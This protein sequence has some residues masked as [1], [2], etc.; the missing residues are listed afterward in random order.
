MSNVIGLKTEDSPTTGRRGVPRVALLTLALGV[1]TVVATYLWVEPRWQERALQAASIETLRAKAAVMPENARVQYYLGKRLLASGD[2]SGA[3]DAL[4]RAADKSPGDFAVWKATADAAGALNGSLGAINL[5]AA[6]VKNNPDNVVARI[7]FSQAYI[8]AGAYRQA[9]SEAKNA[10]ELA[11]KSAEA[12]R[13][14]GISAVAAENA[15]DAEN[16]LR[17]AIMLAP[18]DAEN[19]SALGN[20]LALQGKWDAALSPYREAVRLRP[21][22]PLAL[23]SL[24][25]TLLSVTTS[26]ANVTEAKTLLERSA[27]LKIDL[28]VTY[29]YLGRA[30]AAEG[31]WKG[32][33]TALEHAVALDP[34]T[35]DPYFDLARVYDHFGEKDAAAAARTKH[36]SISQFVVWR[37]R[38]LL[39][40][41]R[42]GD[43]DEGKRL[44]WELARGYFAQQRFQQAVEQYRRLV[45]LYP[46]RADIQSEAA[47]AEENILSVPQLVSAGD[48]ALAREEHED[49]TRL[50]FMAL[51]RDTGN[52]RASEGVGLALARSGKLTEGIRFLV[53]ATR[54]DPTRT[55]AQIALAQANVVAGELP[56]AYRRAEAVT[57]ADPHNAAAWN[58]RGDIARQLN[59]FTAAETALKRAVAMDSGN[60]AYWMNLGDMQRENNRLNEAEASYRKAA[61]LTPDAAETQSRFGGLLL[62]LP[63]NP[64][65]RQEAEKRLRA[66]LVANPTD[67]YAQYNLGK[68]LL[69]KGQ[70]KEAIP[71]LEKVVGGAAT[72][73]KKEVWYA[74]GRAYRMAG[75]VAKAAVATKKATQMQTDFDRFSRLKEQIPLTPND[76]KARLALG[77]AFAERGQFAA[78][79]REYAIARRLAPEMA[80]IRIEMETLERRLKAEGRMPDMS[81]FASILN[82][83]S[84]ELTTENKTSKDNR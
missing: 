2:V 27:A 45:K 16:S 42:I 33:R 75:E 21:D 59:D 48:S 49:A 23:T 83:Q 4:T 28:P 34:T 19:H 3:F 15:P 52:A 46:D 67:E 35:E 54:R 69:D 66:A 47:R 8:D 56:E 20:A 76:F 18:G 32:A 74:L 22:D 1:L 14:R 9:Y 68:C 17:T 38:A 82:T 13:L 39:T 6:F 64:A 81:L 12:W 26:G 70:A 55:M 60:A 80:A 29:L 61:A 40:L 84:R 72:M 10:T 62:Q 31:N 71:I 37:N 7:A 77:R 41:S 36:A 65:R 43:S 79:L 63:P 73:D 51:R 58:M 5:L 50:Y 53:E 44:R 57:E 30:Y 24:A 25:R 11:P 78:A